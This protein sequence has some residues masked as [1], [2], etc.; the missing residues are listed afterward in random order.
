MVVIDHLLGANAFFH[1]ADGNGHAV[2]VASTDEKDVFFSC[3]F[4]PDINISRNIATGKMSYMDGPVSVGKG[5]GNQD[6][7]VF[8]HSLK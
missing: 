6:S 2:L 4:I 8:F 7:V 3:P 5:S 1:G